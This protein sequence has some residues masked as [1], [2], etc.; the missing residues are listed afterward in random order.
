MAMLLAMF[1][2]MRLVREKNQLVLEQTQYSSK[3]SRLEKNIE[4][5]Q[6]YYTSLFAQIDS[7]AKMMESQAKVMFQGMWN[8]GGGSVDPYNYSGMNGFIEN[9]MHQLLSK[10]I[11][12]GKDEDGNPLDPETMDNDTLRA[13]LQFYNTNG[14]L[15]TYKDADGNIRCGSEDGENW[16]EQEYKLFTAA[17]SMA[18]SEQQRAQYNC[19]QMTQQYA[20]NVSIWV[21]AQKAQLEAEQDAV[22]EPLNYEQT[23]LELDKDLKEQR[24]TR[25]NAEIEKY[26]SLCKEETQKSAPSFGLG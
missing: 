6:K 14:Q 18:K 20:N 9:G 11:V 8:L 21:E 5:K 4:R 17:M 22:L 7:Q 2:K 25:I 23:M 24:L 26:E 16:G 1:Q 12:L 3:L 19:N 13:M 15:P 10:G